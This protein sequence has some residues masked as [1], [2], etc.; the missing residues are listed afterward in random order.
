MTDNISNDSTKTGN[1][2][3]QTPRRMSIR[4]SVLVLLRILSIMSMKTVSDEALAT[5]LMQALAGYAGWKFEYVK[6]GLVQLFLISLKNG[7]IDVIGDISYTDERHTR[8]AFFRRN[9]WVRKNISFMPI[10]RIRILRTS[11]FKSMNGKRVGV[12]LGTEPER[13]ADRVGEEEWH[14]YRAC[15]C[16]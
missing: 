12:L 9:R 4:S 7:E 15:K 1:K 10:Y 14:T 5:K 16:I 8:D 3:G 11:D 13:Y 6:C 2:K